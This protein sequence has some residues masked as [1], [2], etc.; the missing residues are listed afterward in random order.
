[1][2]YKGLDP[3][4]VDIFIEQQRLCAELTAVESQQAMQLQK[5]QD[6]YEESQLR[7][8]RSHFASVSLCVM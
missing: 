6:L 4:M 5:L 2:V 7:Q 3:E 8:A 1:M